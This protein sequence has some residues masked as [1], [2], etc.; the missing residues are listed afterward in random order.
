MPRKSAHNQVSFE[1]PCHQQHCCPV[2]GTTLL[3]SSGNLLQG[4]HSAD[5]QGHEPRP[6]TEEKVSSIRLSNKWRD[7]APRLSPPPMLREYGFSPLIL[8][9]YSGTTL[10]VQAAVMLHNSGISLWGMSHSVINSAANTQHHTEIATKMPLH[11]QP[12]PP[13]NILGEFYRGKPC[14][15]SEG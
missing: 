12:P 13:N 7:H 5:D 11:P 4:S 1:F 10:C 2:A 14:D 15:F 6:K 8:P 9:Y 3:F